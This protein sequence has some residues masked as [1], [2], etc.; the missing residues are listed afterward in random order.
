MEQIDLFYKEKEIPIEKQ[1]LAT[2]MCPK[3]F[4][5]FY[6][7][8]HIIG[9]DKLLRRAI[10]SDRLTS[11]IFFGP[12]GTGKT[13]LAKIIAKKTKSYFVQTNAVT[14][15][16]N[17]IRKIIEIAKN[18]IK[19]SGIRTILLL[20]EIHHFNKIQQDAL[21]PNLENGNI[22]LI[23]TTTENPFFYVNQGILSRANIFEFKKH[24]DENIR[25]IINRAIS[26]KEYGLGKQ[27]IKISE[28]AIQYII[29]FS[30]GDAR[31]ALNALEIGVITTKPDKNNIINFDIKVAQECIQKKYLLYDKNG[32]QHYD[33]ISAFI[34]S[35]RGSDPDASLYWLVKML[36]AGEDPRYIARRLI[37]LSSEDIGNADPQAL[38]LTASLLKAIE[39]VGLPEAKIPLAQVTLYLACAPKSNKS[40]EAL[41]LA[42]EE[43]SKTKTQDVPQHLKDPHLDGEL[44]GHGK[45]YLY[46]HSYKDHFVLQKYLEIKKTFYNPSNQGFENEIRKNL[47]NYKIKEKKYLREKIKSLRDNLSKEKINQLSE[48]IQKNLFELK[49][50]KNSNTIMF[51][52]NFGS[53]VNTLPMIKKALQIGKKI[54]LP[55]INKEKKEIFAVEISDINNL[56]PGTFGILE[57]KDKTKI[58]LEKNIDLIIVPGII[59]DKTG[60][61]IG[62][63]GGYYDKW[64]KKFDIK[65]RIGLAFDFQVLD[66][67]PYTE[68]DQKVYKI[69]TERS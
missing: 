16:I 58:I 5:E 36:E 33:H 30:E 18:K 56:Q 1:P 51:F 11:L 28:D 61:R 57:P 12:P 8:E 53:E 14:I 31:K 6:G 25:K 35:V 10:E 13:A 39:F 69:I 60:N 9:E 62:Y 49:E 59:F 29:K 24:S 65:K 37:I 68:T 42:E 55:V 23:G 44:L 45:E 40:Y 34:K 4:N 17:E 7:Q 47:N 20:D 15:G 21:L 19:I 50:F 2:K 22:I 43:I 3:D 67:I 66:S 52:V 41:C 38:I 64:L 27:K 26:D 48:K 46:P 32:D 54:V 63:G